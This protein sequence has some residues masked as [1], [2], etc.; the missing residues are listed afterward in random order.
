MNRHGSYV[1]K[2]D[3]HM[4]DRKKNAYYRA[5]GYK[6]RKPS[7]IM[8]HEKKRRKKRGG[9]SLKENIFS[10]GGMIFPNCQQR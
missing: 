1:R 3:T 8:H 5:F 7:N 6:R 4:L 10:V 9:V 2:K